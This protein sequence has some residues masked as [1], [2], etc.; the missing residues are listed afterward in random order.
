MK[1]SRTTAAAIS[2]A[3]LSGSALLLSACSDGSDAGVADQA[4]L[5][6]SSA[7]RAPA[8]D[9][10]EQSADGSV[11]APEAAGDVPGGSQ[12][13]ANG[14]L[15]D[16]VVERKVIA[17]AEITL[18]SRDVGSTVDA[19]ES[20]AIA[21]NGYVSARDVQNNPDDP[22]R[23][24]ATIAVRVPTDKLDSVIEDAQDEGDAV[25]VVSDEQDVTQTVV[26]VNSRVQSARASVDR[27]RTLLSQANTIGAV[28]RI[29]SELSHRE[30]DLESL[31]AQQRALADQTAMAT[32]SVTVLAPEAAEPTPSDD[33]DQG[34]IAG[35]D[36]G[37]NALVDAVVVALTIVGV[38]LP[39]LVVGAI[40]LVPVLL[41]W[42]NRR[43]Q[44]TGPKDPEPEPVG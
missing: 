6:D 7:G 21:A 27:I 12:N 14:N 42:R 40:V 25:R 24:R 28:V 1:G 43:P 37:W 26:D 13:V 19:I 30:A 16:V 39:F 41:A 32:L 17:T 15:A 36:R 20:I 44:R 2:I 11:P 18:R 35:L 34:F 22:D 4:S 9:S 31:L 5:D 33:D 29:E 23:T 8:T 38:M 3:L 10:S